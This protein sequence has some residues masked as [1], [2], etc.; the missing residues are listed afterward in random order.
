MLARILRRQV[1]SLLSLHC[2]HLIHETLSSPHTSQWTLSLTSAPKPLLHRRT[3]AFL[4][5]PRAE[6]AAT[7]TASSHEHTISVSLGSWVDSWA[8]ANIM[9]F[10]RYIYAHSPF[11][12]AFAFDLIYIFAGR[13]YPAWYYYFPLFVH[14]PTFVSAIQHY[15]HDWRALFDYLTCV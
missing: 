1:L 14:N 2:L 8:Y 7:H 5:T 11:D 10:I 15:V 4:A 6:A 9:Q 12:T 13:P 3:Q